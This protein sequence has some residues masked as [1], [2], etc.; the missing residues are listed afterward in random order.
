MYLWLQKQALEQYECLPFELVDQLA[1]RQ[2]C[3]KTISMQSADAA[4]NKLTEVEVS[5]IFL[6]A[7]AFIQTL[8]K[9]LR[10][11]SATLHLDGRKAF[12]HL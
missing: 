8:L 5:I 10:E 2:T 11:T 1:H 12:T 9:S 6:A 3:E 4:R 7:K